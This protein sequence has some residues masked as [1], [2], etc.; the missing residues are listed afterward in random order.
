MD[1]FIISGVIKKNSYPDLISNQIIGAIKSGA[2]KPGDMLPSEGDFIKQMDVGR[3]S[4]R[5]A[6]AALEYLSVIVLQNGRYYVNENVQDFFRKKLLYHYGTREHCREDVF[7]VRRMLETQFALL[8][9]QRA[10]MNDLQYMCQILVSISDALKNP[11]LHED[12]NF[13]ETVMNL[14]ISFHRAL[15]VATNNNL[16]VLIFDRFKDLIFFSA[17]NN[18]FS[19][20][21]FRE[22]LILTKKLVKSID[23]R[24]CA[25]AV[26]NMSAYLNV[27]E[28]LYNRDNKGE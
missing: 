27:V 1:S 22:P 8:A 16:L 9:A 5:E 14:F 25:E 4:V 7:S 10:T 21:N 17:E 3:T 6:L 15:A 24:D 11:D 18:L 19:R 28:Q 26:A 23:E 13:S 12:E 20:A 2:L